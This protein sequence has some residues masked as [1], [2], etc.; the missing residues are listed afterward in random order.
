[1]PRSDMIGANCRADF[2]LQN[3]TAFLG[4]LCSRATAA[5]NDHHRRLCP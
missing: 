2:V 1:M 3:V 4:A 5:C